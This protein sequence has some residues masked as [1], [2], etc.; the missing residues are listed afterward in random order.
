MEEGVTSISSAKVSLSYFPFRIVVSL[1]MGTSYTTLHA[2]G[3]IVH[4][5]FFP[6]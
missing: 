3:Y 2:P 4:L 1:V 6:L 5:V